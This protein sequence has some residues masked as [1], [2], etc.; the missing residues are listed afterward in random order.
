MKLFFLFLKAKTLS[1]EAGSMERGNTW[2]DI[3][4]TLIQTDDY[5]VTGK[6][7]GY[8]FLGMKL[9]FQ[10]QV[11]KEENATRVG[12]GEP[13]EYDTLLEESIEL[14]KDSDEKYSNNT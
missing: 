5:I 10:S 13:S 2:Q 8:H 4:N 1:S 3:A 14:S 11:R 12:G 6:S 9:N 7:L